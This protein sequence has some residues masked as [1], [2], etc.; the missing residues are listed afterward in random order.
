MSDFLESLDMFG[1]QGKPPIWLTPH[2]TAFITMLDQHR[3]LSF[4]GKT[5]KAHI[6]YTHDGLFKNRDD[7]RPEI[8][9]DDPRE[10]TWLLNNRTDF[11][12][13]GWLTLVGRENLRVGVMDNY[14]MLG[15]PENAQKTRDLIAGALA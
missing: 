1:H 7:P 14:T 12:G 8:R 9:P 3:P 2:F 13:G 11:S 6:I 4:K 15:V 5:P 10:M